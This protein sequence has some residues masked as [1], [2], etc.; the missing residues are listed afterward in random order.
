MSLFRCEGCGCVENTALSHFHLIRGVKGKPALCS[1]CDPDI[2]RW[3]GV[4]PKQDADEAG[5]RPLPGTR[6]IERTIEDEA[7]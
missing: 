4:F 5:Y 2:G 1:E 6:Y 3:H 7:G